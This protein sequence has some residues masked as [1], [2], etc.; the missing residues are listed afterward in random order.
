MPPQRRAQLRS[1][2]VDIVLIMS[3][4]D[5]KQSISNH[6]IAIFYDVNKDTLH[7]SSYR[8]FAQQDCVPNLKLLTKFKKKTIIEHAL[9]IDNREFQFNYDLLCDVVD[10]LFVN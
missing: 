8:K 9:N 5:E 7:N 3:A 2:E 10:K 6:A 1:K 4:I